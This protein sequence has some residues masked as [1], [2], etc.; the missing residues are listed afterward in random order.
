MPSFWLSRPSCFG[1]VQLRL[2]HSDKLNTIKGVGFIA[3][4]SEEHG[5]ETS[6]FTGPS[7]YNNFILAV[8]PLW[9]NVMV[10]DEFF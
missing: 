1:L 4:R 7:A 9:Y 2:E 8:N 5:F 10:P 6:S 3:K